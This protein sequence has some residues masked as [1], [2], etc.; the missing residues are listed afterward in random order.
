M[1]YVNRLHKEFEKAVRGMIPVRGC[2]NVA[3]RNN[4]TGE[5]M[6]TQGDLFSDSNWGPFFIWLLNDMAEMDIGALEDLSI[7]SIEYAG[8]ENLCTAGGLTA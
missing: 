8:M 7:K 3:V 6:E 1:K 4:V 2:Y 5:E